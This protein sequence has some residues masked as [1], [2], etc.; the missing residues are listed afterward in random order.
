MADVDVGN[1]AHSRELLLM[2]EQPDAAKNGD[3]WARVSASSRPIV[4]RPDWARGCRQWR[5]IRTGQKEERRSGGTRRRR[6][7]G[8]QFL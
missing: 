6:R 5:S 4:V 1:A 8:R 7:D 2:A 3:C